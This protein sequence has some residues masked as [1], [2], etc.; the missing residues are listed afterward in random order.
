MSEAKLPWHCRREG[1][2]WKRL[3]MELFGLTAKE[4]AENYESWCIMRGRSEA[5]MRAEEIEDERQLRE[6][7]RKEGLKDKP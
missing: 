1:P 2:W 5:R 3:R 4:Q 6:R 7:W